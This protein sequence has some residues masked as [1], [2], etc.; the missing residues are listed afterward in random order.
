MKAKPSEVK[1]GFW[2]AGMWLLGFGWLFLV[3]LG[4]A[5]VTTPPPPP[6]AL[7][8]T[9]L[10][11]AAAIALGT[12]DRWAKIFPGLLA[13]GILG[14][15]LSLADGHAVNHPEVSVSRPEGLV[16]IA[17]FTTTAVLSFTFTKRK[18]HVTDRLALFVF[19]VCFFWQAVAPN[20]MWA[21]LGVGFCCLFF[22]WLYD[23]FQY[24]RGH[25]NHSRSTSHVTA[26]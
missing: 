7:G 12:V 18:L 16:M 13:Y 25:G 24:R 11:A 1:Q 10:A 6:H 2:R 21:A 15:V 26:I 3:F 19:V 5:V 14:S 22:A 9:L 17:F 20:L 23:R 8:W 4:L